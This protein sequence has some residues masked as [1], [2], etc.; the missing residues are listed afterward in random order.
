MSSLRFTILV[1]AASLPAAAA[2]FGTVV[3]VAGGATDLVLDEQR[4]RLYIVNTTQNRVDVY[5]T[6]SRRFLNPIPVGAQPLSAA[7][8]RDRRYLYVTAYQASALDII[9]LDAGTLFKRVSLP[10]APEGVAVGGDERVLITTLGSGANNSEN[11]LL[12]YDPYLTGEQALRAVPTTLPAPA[13]FQTSSTSTR[14]YMA[15]R[16]N[17]VASADGRWI[18]GLNNPNNSSRQLFVF[19]VASGSVLRSR[20]LTSISNVLSVA[21]DGSKFMAGLSLFDTETLAILAQQNTANSLY[22]FP[23]G[24][25]FNTQQNQGGSVFAPDGRTLYSAFNVAPVQTPAASSNTSQLM[26]CDPEHLLIRMGLQLPENLTGNMVIHSNGNVIYALS[27][28]GFM[29]LPVGS[30]YDNPIAHV[31][32][33]VVSLANDQCG[34]T[35]D[36][37]RAE[38]KVRNLGKGRLTATAQIVSTG[39]SVTLPIGG[40]TGPG[41][42]QPGPGGIPAGAGGGAPG[43]QFPVIL[44]QDPA[45]TGGGQLQ[46]PPTPVGGTTSQALTPAQQT[47]V[48]QNAP[49]VRTRRTDT[50][51]IFEFTFNPNAG[52]SLGT[53]TPTDFVV[54]SQEAINIPAQIRVYQNQRNAEAAGD[55]RTVP[56]GQSLAEG[57]VDMV[58]DTQR[59]RLYIANSGL[60]RVEV[61]DIKTNQFLDPISVGQLPR[62]L[63]ITPNGKTLYVANTGGESISIIDLDKLAV[64]GRVKFPPVPY[65]ASFALNTPSIIAATL[66]GLQIVMSDGSLWKVVDNEALPRKGDP[67]IGSST[68]SAPRTMAASPGGEYAVL[69]GGNGTAYLYEAASDQ[70]I[71]S[72]TVVS[73]P[74]QGYFG[75]VAAGPGGQYFVVNGVVLNPSLTPQ[76][77]RSTS[78]RPVAA[79]A[80]VNATTFARFTTPVRSTST[81]T[82]QESAAVELVDINTGMTRGSA[83]TL[84]GPLAA[85]VGTQRS[86]VNGRTM[87]FHA[88][89]NTAY[90][91]TVSGLSIVSFPAA[92]QAP[93]PGQGQAQPGAATSNAVLINS[94]GVV[95]TGDYSKLIAPGSV[96]SIFGQN[97]A[98]GEQKASPPLPYI[99]SGV[100]VT[101]DDAP[102]PLV[103]TSP[104]QVNFY[105]P[106]ETKTGARRLVVRAVDRNLASSSY[107]FSVQKYAPVVLKNPDTGLAAVYR[108]NGTPVTKTAKAKRDETLYLYAMG[109][110]VTK[111]GETEPVRLFFG[112]PNLKQSEMIVDESILAPGM[113]GIYRITLRVPGFHEKGDSLPVRLRIGG[114]DSPASGPVIAVE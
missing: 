40:Q 91:L 107:S 42:T 92:Q 69:L 43:G 80:A 104:I 24:T 89:T 86:N 49:T 4:D 79:V 36:K 60:N 55:I 32:T 51:T 14:V 98:A 10:A 65:N 39:A 63:A 31:E 70:F 56:V 26:L 30:I 44:P 7:I 110:G 88:A 28:S 102:M 68:I 3:S 50:E 82:V 75:P 94:G 20:T 9:D 78:S 57:L 34:V 58:L 17:L 1:L 12:L 53:I 111:N 71:L 6:T 83:T 85:Q 11:R 25:N 59:Q 72:Q 29:I 21:P 35:A 74:I 19:E 8:S 87:A 54:Q 64:T 41:I 23:G 15:T 2:T 106:A 61:F 105:L 101:V 77:S 76:S 100:C 81:A 18:I 48:A 62:S 52:R 13:A 33:N 37:R 22:P 97:L 67:V 96:V 113:L 114:V 16:S 73:T 99:M 95:N 112:D 103:M 45:G 84:E 66:S 46:V 108:L 38:V 109:L 47:G 5:S 90:V 93:G 27:Q